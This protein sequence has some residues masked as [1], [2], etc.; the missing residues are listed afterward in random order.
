MAESSDIA[1]KVSGVSKIYQ[2]YSSPRLRLLEILKGGRRQY[3]TEKKALDN[4]SFCLKR[5]ERLGIVGTNGSGKSTLLKMLAGVLMPSSGSIEVNGRVSALLELGAGFNPDLPGMDNIAQFCLLH[6]MTANEISE[7]T[8][9]IVEF[10][11]LGDAINHPVRTYSSGMGVRLGFAC[12]VY[13]RPDILIVDE[14]L[15][16]GDS[17]FQN[18]CL[19]KIQAMLDEG[20]TFLYV[21]HSADSVRTLCDRALWLDNGVPRQIGSSIDVG[22]A[23][24]SETFRRSVLAGFSES[25]GTAS[26]EI[27][28]KGQGGEC[29]EIDLASQEAF[30][31]R[32]K[33]LRTG[34]GEILI[35]DI[36]I[37]DSE[38]VRTDKAEF[39]KLVRVRVFFHVASTAP[40]NSALALNIADSLG[41]QIL[42]FNSQVHSIYASDALTNIPHYIEFEFN[43]PLCPGEYSLISG[44]AKLV[45]GPLD[46]NKTLIESVVDYC[47]G[48]ARFSVDVPTEK[49]NKDLWGVVHINYKSHIRSLG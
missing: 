1:I 8:P 12:A 45:P 32:V 31:S 48:G 2:T 29:Q 33:P 41:N 13:V 4:I 9:D 24:L 23:Y 16:V 11:E 6:G 30:Y 39:D 7:A 10:S 17:Y 22:A 15:S 14:A 46:K 34:S 27:G 42:H 18:K 20:V 44:I 26:E 43:N 35:D 49:L 40:D 19:H 21:T 47:A 36:C 28:E 37:I 25:T 5:G 3:A 38:G